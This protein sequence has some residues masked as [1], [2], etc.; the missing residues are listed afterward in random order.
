LAV[1]AGTPTKVESEASQVGSDATGRLQASGSKEAM[2][3]LS[4]TLNHRAADQGHS[5]NKCSAVSKF[6]QRLAISRSAVRTLFWT[7]NHASSLHLA[8][9][10]ACQIVDSSGERVDPRNCVL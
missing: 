9:A 10:H 1:L 6:G 2:P 8:G 7:N 5:T 3:Y 4:A